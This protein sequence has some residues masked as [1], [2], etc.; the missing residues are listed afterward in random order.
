[1]A[2]A[3]LRISASDL[4]SRVRLRLL[5]GAAETAPSVIWTRSGSELLVHTSSLLLRLTDGWLV[6]DVELETLET[7]RSP[8]RC[9]FFLGRDQLGD[10]LK[11]AA[12]IAPD[13][14][15]LLSSTWG[16]SLQ[17]A[18]WDGVQDVLQGALERAAQLWP[19]KT[20]VLSG[21][22]AKEGELAVLVAV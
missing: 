6:V 5:N 7:G 8:V 15:P 3:R 9:L 21:F 10:G 22:T 18:I 11:A 16:E 1:M 17:A 19:G 12:R 13:V 20:P 14:S 2:T 4:L